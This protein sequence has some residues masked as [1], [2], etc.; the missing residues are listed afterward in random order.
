MADVFAL[1]QNPA[2]GLKQIQT[3]TQAKMNATG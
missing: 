1:K 3:L 2:D